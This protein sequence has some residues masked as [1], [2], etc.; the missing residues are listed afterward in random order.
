MFHH[1]NLKDY[2]LKLLSQL[3]RLTPGASYY[4]HK[5]RG[6]FTGSCLKQ[7]KVSY[8]HKKI[9]NIYIVY[10]LGASGSH[11]NDPTLNNCL[12]SAITLTKNVWN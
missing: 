8:T 1:G 4:G 3:L 10:E 11:I 12:F 5:T 6:K 9:V 2:L 7:L